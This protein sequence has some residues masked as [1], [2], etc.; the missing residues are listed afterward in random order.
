[1]SQAQYKYKNRSKNSNM[2]AR[3]CR[4]VVCRAH[5]MSPVQVVDLVR[6]VIAL[7]H[8]P[9]RPAAHRSCQHR[10]PV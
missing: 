4:T 6:I 9:P 7:R 5:A 2:D 3:H 1:M 10:T 8:H